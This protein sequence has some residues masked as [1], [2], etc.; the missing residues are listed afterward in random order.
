VPTT[1]Q[2]ERN[3]RTYPLFAAVVHM[4]FFVPI[5]VLFWEDNGLDM[6]DIFVLQGLFAV[7]MGVLE[8]P[9]GMIADRVGKR[10][11]LLWGCAIAIAA[12]VVYACGHS[13][14]VF[15]VAEV[16]FALALALFSGAD[17]SLLYDSLKALGRED[18]YTA[19]EGRARAWQMLSIAGSTL[20]GGFIGAVS[21]RGALWATV[22]GPVLGLL[23]ARRFVEV[24][25]RA[26]DQSLRAAWAGY[27][28]LLRATLKLV[29]KHALVR[30]LLLFQAVFTGTSTWL[31]WMYQPY[32]GHVGWPIWAFGAG[33]AAF[34]LFAAFSSHRAQRVAGRLGPHRTIVLL[35]LL[36]ALPPLF[37]ANTTAGWGVLL[38]FGHQAV[39]GI[40]RPVLAGRILSQVWADKR[41]TVLSVSSLFSRIFFA[42]SAPIVGAA[43]REMT[44]PDALLFQAVCT[45]V[46]LAALFEAYRR[47]PPKYFAVKASVRRRQ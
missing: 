3:L 22:L 36:Q 15:L 42:M 47:T 34:N 7:A 5:V 12:L 10:T 16:L 9:T 6:L 20:I 37:M 30:R 29:R 32:M 8:V 41:S 35:I 2:L 44:I 33:F 25:P 18:E 11:S 26:A 17:T 28:E 13:F 27:L 14:G 43:A 40:A 46:I 45:A 24:Q 23:V 19:R 38:I 21:L 39:R 4:P 1:A 31:L